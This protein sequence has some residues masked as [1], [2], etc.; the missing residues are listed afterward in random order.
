MG[1]KRKCRDGERI[2]GRVEKGNEGGKYLKGGKKPDGTGSGRIIEVFIR[3]NH[4]IHEE[5][6]RLLSDLG[7]R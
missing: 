7:L 5:S 2:R 4:H 1:R 6:R 3:S